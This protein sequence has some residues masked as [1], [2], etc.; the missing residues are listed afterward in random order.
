MSRDII[1]PPVQFVYCII[2]SHRHLLQSLL[3]VCVFVSLSNFSGGQIVIAMEHSEVREALLRDFSQQ[4]VLTWAGNDCHLLMLVQ[5]SAISADSHVCSGL[6]SQIEKQLGANRRGKECLH[7]S[8]ASQ[9]IVL[10]CPL[11]SPPP[12]YLSLSFGFYSEVMLH[13]LTNNFLVNAGLRQKQ[14]L[15]SFQI[16]ACYS[17]CGQ[18]LSLRG[19]GRVFICAAAI[20]S[21][22]FHAGLRNPIKMT[23]YILSLQDL[24][25]RKI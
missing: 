23:D 24:S 10:N 1:V 15:W 11:Y 5:I 16:N 8:S 14:Q 21:R 4:I 7:R 13:H 20:S 25:L 12:L 3:I 6:L 22:R 17:A 2:L 19:L 9:Q 18:S